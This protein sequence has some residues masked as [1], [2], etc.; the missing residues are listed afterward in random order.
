MNARAGAVIDAY[1][2]GAR[3]TDAMDLG[4]HTQLATHRR[5]SRNWLAARSRV[6]MLRFGATTNSEMMV[7]KGCVTRLGARDRVLLL[8]R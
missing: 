6:V 3:P 2:K 4:T 7:R 8:N 5:Y 1:V